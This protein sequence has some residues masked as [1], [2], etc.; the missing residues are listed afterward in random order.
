MHPTCNLRTSKLR[1]LSLPGHSKRPAQQNESAK[2]CLFT[3]FGKSAWANKFSPV[4]RLFVSAPGTLRQNLDERIFVK[5]RGDREI[6]GRP[7]AV[8]GEGVTNLAV[9]TRD[10]ILWLSSQPTIG[11]SS[12]KTG[13]SRCQVCIQSRQTRRVLSL[14]WFFRWPCPGYMPTI[15]T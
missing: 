7:G 15:S 9:R 4:Q 12:T 10:L 3:L 11:F 14:L 1:V 5:C 2:G 13:D 8:F 6:R